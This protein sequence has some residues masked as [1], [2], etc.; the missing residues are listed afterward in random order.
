MFGV[1]WVKY[2]I[3]GVIAALVLSY[4]GYLKIELSS[5]RHDLATETAKYELYKAEAESTHAAL[6]I[7]FDAMTLQFKESLVAKNKANED[8]LVEVQKRI[9]SE[10]AL[11][12][13]LLPPVAVELFNAGKAAGESGGKVAP[14]AKQG[15]AN[16]GNPAPTL[17]DLLFTVKVNEMYQDKC[18]DA[19]TAWQDWWRKF[20]DSVV[21]VGG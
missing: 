14:E 21:K 1:W 5:A 20:E 18:V 19:L 16:P 12:D 13:V 17:A 7:A 15:N 3:M 11:A 8:K 2:A 10:K 9:K 6:K 4:I